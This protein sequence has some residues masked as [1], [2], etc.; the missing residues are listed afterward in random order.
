MSIFKKRSK[1]GNGSSTVEGQEEHSASISKEMDGSIIGLV[2]IVLE[3]VKEATERLSAPPDV[4]YSSLMVLMNP[5]CPPVGNN[6]EFSA[7]VASLFKVLEENGLKP[8]LESSVKYMFV[9]GAVLFDH[10]GDVWKKMEEIA[11]NMDEEKVRECLRHITDLLI[12][13]DKTDDPVES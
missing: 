5:G 8:D 3:V 2:Q 10:D 4:L 7:H 11:P 6:P 9:L 13:M 1:G 12:K